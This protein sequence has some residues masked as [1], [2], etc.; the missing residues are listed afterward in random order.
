MT[1]GFLLV[2]VGNEWEE[3][4][5]PV[6][7]RTGSE[8]PPHTAV[9]NPGWGLVWGLQRGCLKS[10]L[11]PNTLTGHKADVLFWTADKIISR[12]DYK[13][14]APPSKCSTKLQ[15]GLWELCGLRRKHVWLILSGLGFMSVFLAFF[16]LFE[17]FGVES[18]L[19]FL[20]SA[21]VNF[22]SHFNLKACLCLVGCTC[23][24]WKPDRPTS[25][26]DH[27]CTDMTENGATWNKS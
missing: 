6:H 22:S 21:S 16:C 3:T 9:C 2:H 10:S 4:S 24:T 18:R 14:T 5:S 15:L 8:L 27:T 26:G 17:G 1:A 25:C 13:T 11:T 23:L 20:F 12:L 7:S 19:V